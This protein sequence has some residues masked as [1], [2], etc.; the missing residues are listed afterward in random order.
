MLPHASP[1]SADNGLALIAD[2]ARLKRAA[3]SGAGLPQLLRG[4]RLALLSDD[5]DGPAATAFVRAATE[6]GGQVARVRASG[7]GDRHA[8]NLAA[9]L[10]QLYDAIECQGLPEAELRELGRHAG[11]PVFDGIAGAA[12]PL[13]ELADTMDGETACNHRHLLQAVLAAALG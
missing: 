8:R 13:R 9:L 3:A 2:A 12:H 5:L 1:W 4:K 6:L 7:L 10:G 11:V